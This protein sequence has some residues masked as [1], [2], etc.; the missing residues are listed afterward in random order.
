[1][2]HQHTPSKLGRTVVIFTEKIS[3]QIRALWEFCFDHLGASF[4]HVKTKKGQIIGFWLPPEESNVRLSADMIDLICRPAL[5]S[6]PQ[7]VYSGAHK[8]L[9]LAVIYLEALLPF[10]LSVV[11]YK[12]CNKIYIINLSQMSSILEQNGSLSDQE[13]SRAHQKIFRQVLIGLHKLGPKMGLDIILFEQKELLS[14][15]N[16]ALFERLF[17]RKQ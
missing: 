14:N 11:K 2:L 3:L 10:V 15:K 13:V 7:S 1:M 9:E 12:I 5:D 16:S 4:G 6:G 8:P 17:I